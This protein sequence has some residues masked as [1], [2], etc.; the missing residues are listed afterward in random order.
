MRNMKMLRH[1]ERKWIPYVILFIL[2]AFFCEVFVWRYG[3]FGAKVDWISQHSVLPDYFRQ[4]F[5]ETGNLFPEFA[6]N[7]G[8]GQNIYNFAY[9]GLYSPVIL[10]SYLLPFVKMSDYMMAVQF[11][12]LALSVMLMYHW[13]KKRGFSQILSFGTAI[14]FLL[15]GPMIYHSYNQIMFVNYMPFLCMGLLGVDCYFEK[16]KSTLL[17]VSVFLMIM[18]SFYF[19]IGGMLVLVLYGVHRYFELC[20][21]RKFSDFL[22]QGICFLIPFITAVLLS[23]VLLLSAAMAIPGREGM[24]GHISLGELLVPKISPDRFFYTPYGIGLTTLAVTALI[25]ML[26]FRKW[27]E[28]VLAWECAV[29]LSV[30]VFAYLQNGGLYIRDKV[31]I[32]FLP[33]LCYV[34]VYYLRTLEFGKQGR[35]LNEIFPYIVSVFLAFTA[36]ERGDVGKYWYLL[37]LDGAVM[38]ACFL[39]FYRK[40]KILLLLVPPIIFLFLFG[41]VL[42]VQSDRTVDRAFYEEV[43]DEDMRGLITKVTDEEDGF[44]RTEQLGTEEE[45]AANLNRIHNMKQYVSSIYSS[46]YHSEYQRFRTEIFELEQPFRNFLMQSAVQNP[47]YQRFM[48]VK[49]VISD[50]RVH[51]NEDVLPVA[52]ATNQ[53]IEEKE[54]KKLEFP[55]NQLALLKY[56][57]VENEQTVLGEGTEER[58]RAEVV[59]VDLK[60][61]GMIEAEK[62]KT[63]Q[64]DIPGGRN[65]LFL[66]FTVKNRKPSKD[67]AIW[68]EGVRNKLTTENHFYYNDNTTFTYVVPL[69]EE[70]K[71]IEI[72]F[73]KGKYEIQDVSC[74]T[75]NLP[76]NEREK[77]VQAEFR[78]DKKKTKG[79]V[80]AGEITMEEAGYFITS[81]PYDENFKI[82]VNGKEVEG[83]KV[84]TVFLG[85][86]LGEGKHEITITYHAPGSEA[87]KWISVAGIVV[88]GVMLRREKRKI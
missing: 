69:E 39:L 50:G 25:S 5:Y 23:G 41:V 65:V 42:H 3:I 71:Q 74:Y 87:G 51:V 67:I 2:T 14:M 72:K 22:L 84:N 78:V 85:F 12:C 16:K 73:G 43:T 20:D 66:Q 86:K 6:L 49:Y 8:G 28:R 34:I 31:M 36:R 48:G 37:L 82:L 33:L 58:D 44:Y 83:E 79:N 11:L 53:T 54:Y 35:L 68:V 13:L 88:F 59:P 26:F 62:N 9:Y 52:Y 57:V 77:L 38:L 29:V 21:V 1:K 70:Q 61:P 30:P 63:I 40:R 45:N 19:S 7:I 4:Q 47:V 27:S 18:S 76:D 15:S 17:T 46:A 75:G 10:P 80:I 24:T 60:L 56:V 81:I 32:P 64:A 55:Y